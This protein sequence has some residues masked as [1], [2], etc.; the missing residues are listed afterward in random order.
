MDTIC[1]V[2]EEMLY[3]RNYS[4]IKKTILPENKDILYHAATEYKQ[5]VYCML[6]H[7]PLNSQSLKTILEEVYIFHIILVFESMTHSV[8]KQ[9]PRLNHTVECFVYDELKY[10]IMKHYLVP[11]HRRIQKPKDKD[12]EQYPKIS[13]LDAVVRFLGFRVG[14]L[15][16]IE[17]RNGTVYYRY[18]V[19]QNI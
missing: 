4:F 11:K 8:A 9:I 6:M 2:F 5:P 1:K 18:V 12:L 14:D 19:E 13:T 17:R 3:A 7:G 15:L 16:E 10:N